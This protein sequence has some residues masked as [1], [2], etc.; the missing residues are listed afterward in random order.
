[1][2]SLDLSR[3]RSCDAVGQAPQSQSRTF[4]SFD[5]QAFEDASHPF[6]TSKFY[7]TQPLEAEVVCASGVGAVFLVYVCGSHFAF[8]KRFR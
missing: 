6:S 8:P 2:G 1:M 7:V 5:S 4:T 3:V